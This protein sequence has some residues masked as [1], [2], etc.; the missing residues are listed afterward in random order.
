MEKVR[1]AWGG[2]SAKASYAFPTGLA[3]PVPGGPC[4]VYRHEH[5][6][7]AGHGVSWSCRETVDGALQGAVWAWGAAGGKERGF[8]RE[9]LDSQALQSCQLE[10]M[11]S[12]QRF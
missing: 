2:G 10:P 9:Q 6:M 7:C 3:S 4:Q 12:R 5:Q 11:I 1:A 8:L